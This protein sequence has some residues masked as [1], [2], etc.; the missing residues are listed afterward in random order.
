MAPGPSHESLLLGSEM[1]C[2]VPREHAPNFTDH[3]S[4]APSVNRDSKFF[5]F[6]DDDDTPNGFMPPHPEYDWD[7]DKVPNHWD[8]PNMTA[9]PSSAPSPGDDI[10]DEE[11]SL[12]VEGGPSEPI[13]VTTPNP[14]EVKI[15]N[16]LKKSP[17]SRFN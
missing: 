3:P 8:V 9:A 11:V 1:A 10:S 17:F 6:Q 14:M 5:R 4:A 7:Y 13:I 15:L 2:I 16:K 12:E